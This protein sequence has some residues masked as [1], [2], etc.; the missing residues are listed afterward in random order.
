MPYSNLLNTFFF[1]SKGGIIL[2]IHFQTNGT[3][4]PAPWAAGAYLVAPQMYMQHPWV[5]ATYLVAPQ[6]VNA[7]PVGDG[8]V[9]CSPL[10]VHAVP[11]GDGHLPCSLPRRTCS[12][13]R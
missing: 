13:R 12:A 6:D 11:V 8:C 10:D 1:F 2:Q 3:Q 4:L 9:P 5:T 7:V